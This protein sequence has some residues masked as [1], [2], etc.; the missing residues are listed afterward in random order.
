MIVKK[1]LRT[2]LNFLNMPLEKDKPR[3]KLSV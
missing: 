2:S 3:I 1:F